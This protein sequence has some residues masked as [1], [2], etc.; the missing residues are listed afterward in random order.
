MRNQ[1]KNF[2]ISNMARIF[3]RYTR[4]SSSLLSFQTAILNIFTR[5]STAQSAQSSTDINFFEVPLYLVGGTTTTRLFNLGH[6]ILDPWNV[7]VQVLF[8]ASTMLVHKKRLCTIWLTKSQRTQGLR[9][10]EIR[11]V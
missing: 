7:L 8:T 11:K 5:V 6:N 1:T 3:G 4:K 10:S 2:S 9:S